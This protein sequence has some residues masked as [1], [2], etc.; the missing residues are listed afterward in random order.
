[1][2]AKIRKFYKGLD[3]D[4]QTTDELENACKNFYDKMNLLEKSETDVDPDEIM[5]LTEQVKD[6]AQ[7]TGFVNGFSFALDL[8]FDGKIKFREE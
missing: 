2:N 7:F 8:I 6:E 5:C 3:F 1:M 4:L